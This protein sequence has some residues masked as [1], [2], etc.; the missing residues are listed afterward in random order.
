MQ[1]NVVAF[2][3]E[4]DGAEAIRVDDVFGLKH[5]TAS[6]LDRLLILH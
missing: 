2:G 5:F 6:L 1:G 4:D 3:V